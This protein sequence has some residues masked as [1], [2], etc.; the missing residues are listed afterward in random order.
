MTKK[1]Y[2]DDTWLDHCQA[3]VLECESDGDH[4]Y[5]VLL[6]QTVILGAQHGKA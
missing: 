5:K 4:G 3:T 6:D 2:Y 1:V